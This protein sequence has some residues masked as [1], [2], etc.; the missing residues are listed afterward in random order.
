MASSLIE[1][2]ADLMLREGDINAQEQR[3]RIA[4]EEETRQGKHRVLRNTL[5]ALATYGP[6]FIPGIGPFASM[7]IGA[8][9]RYLGNN[10]G[11]GSD[12]D[13]YREFYG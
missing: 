3:E 2:I 13:R 6:M 11:I 5:K 4:A 12:E 8:G 7:G 9:M 10:R 1:Q